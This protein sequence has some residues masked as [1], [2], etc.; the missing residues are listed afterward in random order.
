MVCPKC[1]AEN[2]PNAHYCLRCGQDLTST[3]ATCPNCHASVVPGAMF[4]SQCGQRLEPAG[5]QPPAAAQPPITDQASAAGQPPAAGQA[6]ATVQP[7]AAPQ[8]PE[9]APEQPTQPPRPGEA[10]SPPPI[11][12]AE[13]APATQPAPAGS[14]SIVQSIVGDHN[15][16]L[17]LSN[18]N[19]SKV[20]VTIQTPQE[21]KALPLPLDLR[22]P[23][24]QGLLDRQPELQDVVQALERRA[25]VEISGENG[26]GKTTLLWAVGNSPAADLQHFPGGVVYHDNQER[27]EPDLLQSLFALFYQL[28]QNYKPSPEEI[29]RGL[30]PLQALLLL[31]DVSLTREQLTD[32][33]SQAPNCTFVLAT[34]E[35]ALWGEGRSL[36][37]GGLPPAES[38]AL[39]ERELGRPLTPQEQSSAQS[40]YDA[41]K[42]NPDRLLKVADSVRRGQSFQTI[43]QSLAHAPIT[44]ILLTGLATPEMRVL[45]VVALGR[46]AAI[47]LEHIAPLAGLPDAG[48]TLQALQQRRLVQA[49]SPRYS[50]TGALAQEL[51]RDWDLTPWADRALDYFIQW[52][53]AQIADPR[54]MFD[55]LDVILSLLEWAVGKQRWAQVLRLGRAIQ[56]ALAL[57]LRWG[58]W[59]QVLNWILMAARALGE[60]LAEGWA[61]HQI[62]TH[63]L[64]SGNYPTAHTFLT[65]ALELRQAIGD[66]AGL[67]VTQHN[68]NLLLGPLASSSQGKPQPPKQPPHQPPSAPSALGGVLKGFLALIGVAGL[69]AVVV[70]IALWHPWTHNNP[71]PVPTQRPSSTP[72]PPPPSRTPTRFIPPPEPTRTPIP[73]I[74]LTGTVP[75]GFEFSLEGGCDHDYPPGTRQSFLINPTQ[76]GFVTVQLDGQT[77][78][79]FNQMQVFGNVQFSGLILIPRVPGPHVLT[80]LYTVGQITIPRACSFSVPPGPTPTPPPAVSLWLD[81]GQ[82][83]G[84]VAILDTVG[85]H[86][87]ANMDGNVD[88]TVHP[89][90]D[91]SNSWYPIGETSSVAVLANQPAMLSWTAPRQVS[92]YTLQA[93]LNN[94]AATATCDLQVIERNPP[95]ITNIS[96]TPQLPCDSQMVQATIHV[97]DDT[98]VDSVRLFYRSRGADPFS[99]ATAS[100]VDD[101]TFQFIFPAPTDIGTAFYLE[102]R[103]VFGNLF[104]NQKVPHDRAYSGFTET[105]IDYEQYCV[106]FLVMPLT[107]LPALDLPE[108]PTVVDNENICMTQCNDN[109]SCQSFTFNPT[110]NGCWLKNGIPDGIPDAVDTSAVKSTVIIPP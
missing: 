52:A 42:G 12:S 32:L 24:F 75:P 73:T 64:V 93:N 62:G 36:P 67:A 47:P 10:G 34:T 103:D 15:I 99:E 41:L 40:L 20:D 45:S 102:A 110:T 63:A 35:R 70:T 79:N 48:P 60:K 82:C 92:K 29:H 13:I 25:P 22:P 66:Q 19:G 84:Q 23:V 54:R 14:P 72:I 9:A 105:G 74:T 4:C 109:L 95:T 17:N 106:A 58:A 43:Q 59:L 56:A 68:L 96:L 57:A 37:L 104:T 86:V 6:P 38:L 28:P 49:H 39:I 46:R 53:E 18:I 5:V 65:Q 88:F 7:P 98:G 87:S 61:L 83:G 50:L 16:Q 1:G 100:R 11:K 69:V 30:H 108:M 107:N 90:W 94:G 77:I 31:D 55:S 91:T 101:V 80:A 27:P 33:R 97:A 85:I 81:P 71:A 51:W 8:P 89:D 44:P 2:A 76:D 21:T 26:L 3:S 78:P